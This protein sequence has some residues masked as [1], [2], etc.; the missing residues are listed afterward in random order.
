MSILSTIVVMSDTM[1]ECYMEVMTISN[2][3]S[4][5]VLVEVIRSYVEEV[6]LVEV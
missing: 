6:T 5:V 2:M 4:M 1:A 3:G